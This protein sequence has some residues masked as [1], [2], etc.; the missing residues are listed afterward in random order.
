MNAVVETKRQNPLVAI[1]HYIDARDEQFHAALP[2][3]IPVERFKRVVLTAV[4]NNS[5]LARVRPSSLFNA[6]IKAAQDGLLPDGREGAIVPYKDEAQW[7]PMIAGLRKK[8][9]NSGEISTWDVQ[10]V[11]AND[12]FEFE[13]GDNPYILHQPTLEEKGKIIAV[14]SIATLKTGEKSRDVMSIPEINKIRA[15]SK[16]KNSPWNN[17]FDEMAKKTVARRHSKVLPMST[18]LDDLL[19]RDDALYDLKGAS[20]ETQKLARP[21]IAAALDR[22]SAPT[23]SE[24]GEIIEHSNAAEQTL[25]A[26]TPGASDESPEAGV[27]PSESSASASGPII[28]LDAAYQSGR[29]AAMEGKSRRA[30]PAAYREEGNEEASTAWNNGFNEAHD[31]AN[32]GEE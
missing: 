2:A 30:M 15:L 18:D 22:L 9:R 11:Y 32:S 21:S 6:C 1:K 20:D 28:D 3:H 25:D 4:Q 13:L 19:R 17:F 26:S 8:V 5:D 27:A 23:S 7:M 14:Y 10:A 29:K 24:N 12:R 31:E 16:A